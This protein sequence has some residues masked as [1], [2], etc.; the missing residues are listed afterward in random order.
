VGDWRG[1]LSA[2]DLELFRER[3]GRSF[4]ALGYEW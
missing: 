2:E 1:R 4:E 3:A